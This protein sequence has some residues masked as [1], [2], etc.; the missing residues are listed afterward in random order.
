MFRIVRFEE[1]DFG[2]YVRRGFN[3]TKLTV[4]EHGSAVDL[5]LASDA[6]YE[7]EES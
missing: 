5:G 2:E 6:I 7:G 4:R 3:V 1:L